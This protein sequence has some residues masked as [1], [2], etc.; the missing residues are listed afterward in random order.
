MKNSI[1]DST[2]GSGAP[3]AINLPTRKSSAA[4]SDAVMA[5]NTLYISGRLGL[6]LSTGRPPASA[7][8]EARNVLDDL[9]SVLREA[10]LT[11]DDL[12]NVQIFCPDITLYDTFNQV[13]RG[14]FD[15]VL[16]TRAFIGSGPL[17]FG[18]RF[19]LTGIAV[20]T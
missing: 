2:E 15:D 8:Q 17:L 14:Y 5:G 18:A 12:V 6:E 4:F 9:R 19:E 20:R 1:T 13:Y 3:R 11:M 7:E 10:H 16:P